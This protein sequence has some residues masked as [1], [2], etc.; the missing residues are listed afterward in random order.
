M[1]RRLALVFVALAAVALAGCDLSS[2]PYAPTE[3]SGLSP[4]WR[5]GVATVNVDPSAEAWRAVVD[6]NLRQWSV[7]ANFDYRWGDCRE[8][9]PGCVY[10]VGAAING[11]RTGFGTLDDGHIPHAR[12]T[13]DNYNPDPRQMDAVACVELGHAAGLDYGTLPMCGGIGTPTAWDLAVV[14]AVH[15]HG[16]PT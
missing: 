14:A 10:I 9:D 3:P 11:G 4:H 7:A 8:G 15:D 13:F 2:I 5:H 1:T 16:D 6:D 12:I